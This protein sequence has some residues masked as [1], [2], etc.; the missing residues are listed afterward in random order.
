M[1]MMIIVERW[2][3]ELLAKEI[4][5]LGGN[6]PQCQIVH[7]KSHINLPGLETGPPRWEAGEYP[8]D[9]LHG[10]RLIITLLHL[11]FLLLLLLL[12]FILNNHY[13][14][15]QISIS[16]YTSCACEVDAIAMISIPT[17]LMCFSLAHVHILYNQC[18]VLS[19][20]SIIPISVY[21]IADSFMLRFGYFLLSMAILYIFLF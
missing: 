12:L 19:L 10:Q 8:P 15:T 6:L 18:Y 16:G 5:I 2:W 7:S 1:S 11:L 3:N 21:S 13:I 14:S 17:R 20:L 9:V 4:Y